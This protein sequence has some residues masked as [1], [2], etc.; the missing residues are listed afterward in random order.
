MIVSTGSRSRYQVPLS[1][2]RCLRAIA[3]CSLALVANSLT[4]CTV[5]D[6]DKDGIYVTFDNQC[7][8]PI[9]AILGAYPD[10]AE[11]LPIRGDIV[12]TPPGDVSEYW[13][14]FDRAEAGDVYYLWVE[15]ADATLYERGPFTVDPASLVA[16]E[17][18]ND[19]VL[20]IGGTWCP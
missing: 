4:A 9:Y 11:R 14:N 19:Y 12:A 20:P 16:G 18:P 5:Q 10:D 6:P 15:G 17:R 1:G 13:S 3:V 7:A 8:T 2:F